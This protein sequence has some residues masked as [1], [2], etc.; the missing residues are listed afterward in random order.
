[1][2]CATSPPH[3]RAAHLV[4]RGAAGRQRQPGAERGLA[5]RRLAL[6]GGQHAAHDHFIDLFRLEAGALDGG[7]DRDAAELG[8]SQ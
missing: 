6:A 5:R 1:M 3:A 8:A 2:S 7:L 4:H